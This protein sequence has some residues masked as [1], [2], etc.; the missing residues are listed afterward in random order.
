MSRCLVTGHKGY[1]G[2]QLYKKLKE[3]GHE[4]MGID[5]KDNID[6]NSLRG[7][8]EDDKGNFH[9]FWFN[10]KPEYVFHLACL[11]RVGYSIEHPVKTMKNN[12]L[13]GSNVLN[14]ARKVGAKR[15]I[16]SSSSSVVGNGDGPTSPYALQKLTTELETK[17]YSHL[18]GIDTVSLRYFNVYSEDQKTDGPYATA[19]ANWMHSLRENKVP[20]IT[21]D[22]EQRRD[23][24]HVDDAVSANIFSMM[25]EKNFDGSVFDTGTGE[26]ISLNEIKEIVQNYFPN[27]GFD[28]VDPRPGEVLETRANTTPLTNLGWNSR[29]GVKEGIGSCFRNTFLCSRR[30]TG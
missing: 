15:V 12:I 14:F 27:V 28:Y 25:R 16:Y 26:N 13:A 21:G 6:I 9:P 10:F 1:I 29:I 7:L 2:T 30:N 23:M 24:L 19:I 8:V 18:Y 20:F 3:L 17:M 11:P 5:L 4:V 22:G